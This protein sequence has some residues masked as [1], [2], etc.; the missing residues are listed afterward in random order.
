[1]ETDLNCINN[2]LQRFDFIVIF[3]RKKYLLTKFYI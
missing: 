1:M 2:F 3:S